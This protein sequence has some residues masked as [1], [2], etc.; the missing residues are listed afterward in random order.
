MSRKEFFCL[1][2]F[3]TI[4]GLLMY[5]KANEA[6]PRKSDYPSREIN[7]IVPFNP[8]G[9]V[10]LYARAI[11]KMFVKNFNQ[12]TI[13]RHKPGGGTIIGYTKLARSAPDGY[14]MGISVPEIIFHS[15]YDTSRY[16]FLTALDPIA[17]IASIPQ[18]LVVNADSPWH[19]IDDLIQYARSNNKP[20]RFATSGLGSASHVLSIKLGQIHNVEVLAVPFRG[21]GEKTAMLLG[22]HIDAIY[23]S[24]G[25]IREYVKA[26]RL[27]VLATTASTRITDDDLFD[28]I[29]THKELG[30]DIVF[31][32]WYGVVIPKAMDVKIREKLIYMVKEAILDPEFKQII[33]NI[34]GRLE[35]LGPKEAEDKWIEDTARIKKLLEG[36]NIIE[37][38]RDVQSTKE[39][40]KKFVS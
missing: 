30:I 13:L 4:S 27:R 1:I 5:Q 6:L 16:H 14:T 34:G 20:L 39:E 3:I 26:G 18:L 15:I 9:G 36:T 2:V 38:I 23:I 21:G 19:S 10:D 31:D 24:P 29:P 32:D 12:T 11:Q 40:R 35:Y 28:N 33:T 22:N 17:Q 25:A 7:I 8:G 37:T